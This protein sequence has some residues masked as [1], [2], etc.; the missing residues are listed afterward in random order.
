MNQELKKKLIKRNEEMKA[1]LPHLYDIEWVEKTA[2]E[3]WEEM[4]K[5]LEKAMPGFGK[6][7]GAEDGLNIF[8]VIYYSAFE[9][10]L[11]TFF[12]QVLDDSLAQVEITMNELQKITACITT[13]TE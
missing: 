6:M 2:S 8:A 10:A 5:G 13:K 7:A 9:S 4:V 1:A 12:Q 3:G 11:N